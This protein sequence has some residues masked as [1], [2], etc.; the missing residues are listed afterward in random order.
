MEALGRS[1]ELNAPPLATSWGFG[2]AP[3]DHPGRGLEPYR[4]KERALI[5]R[6]IIDLL[7]TVHAGRLGGKGRPF[8]AN[9]IETL[10]L[11]GAVLLGHAHGSPK[12]ASEIGRIVGVPRATALR[13]LEDLQERGIVVRRGSK[14]F[15][16][17]LKKGEDDYID[18]CLALIKRAAQL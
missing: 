5:A 4:A 13:K 6:L 10:L 3:L 16:V 1:G 18:K 9:E 11:S 2:R 15:M 17:E 7:R 14:Y 8:A 12:N